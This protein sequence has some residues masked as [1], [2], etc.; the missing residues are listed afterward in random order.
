M[1]FTVKT[2]E[3]LTGRFVANKFANKMH[4]LNLQ[5]CTQLMLKSSL[6]K[7]VVKYLHLANMA[8]RLRIQK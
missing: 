1:I 7:T 3:L 5:C 4:Y 6:I 8:Y 2:A